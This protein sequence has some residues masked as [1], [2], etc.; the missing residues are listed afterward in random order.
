MTFLLTLQN[1]KIKENVLKTINLMCMLD[2]VGVV[3]DLN[4]R[5]I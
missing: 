5:H 2:V 1:A 4:E 3:G